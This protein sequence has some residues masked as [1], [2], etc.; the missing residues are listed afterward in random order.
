MMFTKL[1]ARGI[2]P[3]D[4]VAAVVGANG[5][6]GFG[7]CRQLSGTVRRLIMVGTDTERLERSA[8]MLRRRTTTEIV[9]STDVAACR[10]A[11]MVF[12]ATSTVPPVLFPEHVKPG[13]VIYDLGRPADV[14]DA[15]LHMDG[16][17]VI[18]G[19]VVRLPG[20]LQQRVDIHFGWR[21]FPACMCETLLIALDECYDRVS[22]G[23]RTRA[24]DIEH[25]VALAE[26]YHFVVVDEAARPEAAPAAR[27][28]PQLQPV[29]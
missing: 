18:P 27:A 3:E 16:V 17:T 22:V 26:Q 10:E 21:Q 19:G 24:E 14:D 12:T 2:A 20:T 15:V 1:Q 4:A 25:F 11:D 23:E 5:V 8:T 13:A 29:N 6:V 9:V 28:V 7:T